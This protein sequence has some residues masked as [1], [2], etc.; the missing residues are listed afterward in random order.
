MASLASVVVASSDPERIRMLSGLLGSCA[1]AP[2][3]SPSLAEAFEV[4]K[5]QP[6]SLVVCDDHLVDGSARDLLL[7]VARLPSRTPV[8]VVSV[9]DDCDYYLEVM[10]AGAF[11]YVAYPADNA[12]MERVMKNAVAGDGMVAGSA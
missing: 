8:I 1:V 10:E 2:I 3:L 9:R 12:E 11:D 7:E 5:R 4:L 6:V